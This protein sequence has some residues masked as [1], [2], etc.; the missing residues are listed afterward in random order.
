MTDDETTEDQVLRVPVAE[1]E[2]TARVV[3]QGQGAVRITKRV[4]EVP[5]RADIDLRTDAV[6]VTRHARDEVVVEARA[7]WYEGDE[8][9]IPLYEE[10]LVTE[11]QIRTGRGGAGA[12]HTLD[13]DRASSG[14]GAAGDHRRRPCSRG[15]RDT[16]RMTPRAVR[17][18]TTAVS[19]KDGAPYWNTVLSSLSMVKGSRDLDYVIGAPPV[20][21]MISPVMYLASCEARK[22]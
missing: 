15:G 5:M 4:E 10:R 16:V 3:E 7:P 12:Q 8:L 22:T 1:E 13:R 2:L 17:S 11:K 19:A 21:P 20:T 9:V 18:G 6:A 14:Y